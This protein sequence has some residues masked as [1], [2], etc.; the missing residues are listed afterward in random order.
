MAAIAR[1]PPPGFGWKINIVRS[2]CSSAALSSF[3]CARERLLQ[4]RLGGLEGPLRL[5][6]RALRRLPRRPVLPIRLSSKK[7]PMGAPQGTSSQEPEYQSNV[8][9]RPGYGAI[10]SRPP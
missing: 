1:L 2:P 3:E 8:E 10:A 7:S 4:Q 6:H 9:K 5:S